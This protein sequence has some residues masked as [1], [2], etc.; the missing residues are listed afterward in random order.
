M[1]DL[2]GNE[3]RSRRTKQNDP[4]LERVSRPVPER[5][6]AVDQTRRANDARSARA[7][8]S[9]VR[10]HGQQTRR[11]TAVTLC[12][13]RSP[14]P[15]PPRGGYIQI[16]EQ[17]MNNRDQTTTTSDQ[18]G[19]LAPYQETGISSLVQERLR[20]IG[21]DKSIKEKIAQHLSKKGG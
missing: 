14:P 6:A 16:A 15:E 5:A 13:R 21:I 17:P 10:Q 11:K 19:P 18:R 2:R 3:N 7:R 20:T 1:D 8:P 9:F 12:G 4:L